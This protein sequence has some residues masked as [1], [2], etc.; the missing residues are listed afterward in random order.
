MPPHIQTRLIQF[1]EQELELAPESV[2][3]ALRHARRIPSSWPMVL[4]QYGLVS[5]AQLDKIFD[6]L[7]T[8]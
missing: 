5:L 7:E 1:L 2:R 3:L 6:W 8:I 4:W